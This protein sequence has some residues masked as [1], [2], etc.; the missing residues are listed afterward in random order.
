MK[1]EIESSILPDNS[2]LKEC[3]N[4][5]KRT[6]QLNI[7][8]EATELLLNLLKEKWSLLIEDRTNKK[9]IWNDIATG[10][11]K[12]GFLVRGEDKGA[13]CRT[14]WENLRKYYRTY[15]SKFNQS[16]SITI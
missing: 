7:G 9:Q 12:Q 16:G 13:T 5:G 4:G 10:L 15:V 11:S 3:W 1:M 6:S 14:K 8:M 2:A